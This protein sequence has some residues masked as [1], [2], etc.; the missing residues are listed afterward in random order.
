MSTLKRSG[1]LIL[2]ALTSFALGALIL[3][4][5]SRLG[6]EK[7]V[8]PTAPTK[9][10]AFEGVAVPACILDFT[11]TLPSPTPTPSPSP[12]PSPTASPS[13]TPTP[14]ASASAS[15]S[16]SPSAS[17]SALPS[18]S[19]SASPSPSATTSPVP[20]ASP[21]PSA[22]PIAICQQIKIYQIDANGNWF[23]ANPATL[24]P[25]DTVYFSVVGFSNMS[26]ADFDKAHFRVNGIPP[27]WQETTMINPFGEFTYQY[28][29]LPG[30]SSYTVEAEI[31]SITLGW[32]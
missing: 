31:H 21:S 6:Q 19:P 26:S 28:T 7:A 30:V 18:V 25:G 13:P 23:L 15:P 32:R 22:S 9:Q 11:I 17:A 10:N 4:T 2:V 14:S 16:A 8:A 12:S 24:K 27:N 5:V 1:G 29:L 20:S 3:L